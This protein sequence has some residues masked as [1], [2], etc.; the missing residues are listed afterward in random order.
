LQQ[1]ESKLS[2]GIG[3]FLRLGRHRGDSPIGGIDD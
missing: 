2:V 1:G 3:D